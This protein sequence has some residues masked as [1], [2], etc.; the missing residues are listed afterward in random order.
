MIDRWLLTPGS[1][2]GS[3]LMSLRPFVFL[4]ACLLGGCER[5]DASADAT[6]PDHAETRS[7]LRDEE[8]RPVVTRREREGKVDAVE[9]IRRLAGQGNS[10]GNLYNEALLAIEEADPTEFEAIWRAL[11]EVKIDVV[12][13]L[14]AQAIY[15]LA[16]KED[17]AVAG[18][19][20][21]E[22]MLPRYG[23]GDRL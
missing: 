3:T 13:T 19:I 23:E 1:P 15:R 12:A 9:V 18:R 8:R 6:L 10:P 21:R 11:D 20:A 2:A 4:T 16:A 22:V 7:S 14:Q 17:L 5:K